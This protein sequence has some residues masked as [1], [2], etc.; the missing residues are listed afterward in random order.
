[1]L[2][3]CSTVTS[4]RSLTITKDLCRHS[5][6]E[7]FRQFQVL[8]GAQLGQFLAHTFHPDGAGIEL[9]VVP[10]DLVERNGLLVFLGVLFSPLCLQAAGEQ[11]IKP[12]TGGVREPREGL[13]KGLLF[14]GGTR[15]VDEPFDALWSR[16]KQAQFTK[17]RVHYRFESFQV[18]YCRLAGGDEPVR[19]LL[20]INR[21]GITE[22]K[23]LTNLCAVIRD[24][25]PFPV[26]LAEERCVQPQL[27]GNIVNYGPGNLMSGGGETPVLAT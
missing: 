27:V 13:G 2:R 10:G 9:E 17:A 1:M 7:I 4:V 19:H 11:H 16:G 15:R 18:G 14:G 25:A 8:Q 21:G 26:V 5:V 12:L 22:L 6:E 3:T 20:R 23:V 24:G